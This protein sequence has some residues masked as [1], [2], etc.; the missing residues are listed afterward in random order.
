MPT[1]TQSLAG[2][3][4]DIPSIPAAIDTLRGAPS[5][6]GRVLSVYLDTSPRR[7]EGRA[8][9]L[10]FRDGCRA[11]RASLPVGEA[12]A[13][14]AAVSQAERFLADEWV[15]SHRGLALFASGAPDYFTAVPLPVAPA[16]DVIWAPSAEIEPLEEIVDDYERVAVVVFDKERTRLFTFV[17][18]AVEEHEVFEDV[19]PG[20]Q[21]T[22]EWFALSQTRYARH[23]EEH[24]L[25]H[26]KRTI[27]ALMAA[28][29]RRP[30][31]R[32]L[33]AGPGE[34]ISL[35][36][37]H[38]PRRLQTRLAGT[39]EVEMFASDADVA[40]AALKEA[41]RLERTGELKIVDELLESAPSRN[42][43]LGVEATLR[44]LAEGRVH[45]LV[46]A[47]TLDADGAA[48]ESCARL[49]S[50]T[51]ARCPACGGRT[52]PVADLPERAVQ[53]AL[54]QGAR[55]EVVSGEAAD[56]L[57]RVGGLAAWTRF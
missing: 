3:R 24:V 18:G 42:V 44:A 9:L 30:F 15:P 20:K 35:L 43:D 46:V 50:A 4:D 21:A 1:T 40:T 26:V 45:Q 38:L 41:E 23:H 5:P 55:V 37:E 10:A 56:R 2:I 27:R 57:L 53:Q 49:L 33:L 51:A 47:S 11:M 39:F 54:A 19:V 31:D 28:L 34:A 48:C 36:K 14:E 29:N 16:E 13:F 25:R 6:V 22:G 32:L 12:D 17:L 8:Y 7:I 52:A